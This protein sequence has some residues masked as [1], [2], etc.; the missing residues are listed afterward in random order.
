MTIAVS[1]LVAGIILLLGLA[2]LTFFRDQ[3]KETIRG[4]QSAMVSAL[5]DGIDHDLAVSRDEIAEIAEGITPA[6]LRDPAKAQ[7]LLDMRGK[8]EVRFDNGLVLLSGD[9]RLIA[10]SPVV[11]GRKGGDFSFREYFRKV[12]ATRKPYI[13]GPYISSN[14]NRHPAIMFAAPVIGADGEL[15]GVMGGSMNLMGDNA[16]GRLSR[17]TVGRS[18]YLSLLTGDGVVVMHPDRTRIMGKDAKPLPEPGGSGVRV[19]ARGVPVLSS[20]RQLSAT[21]WV[22]SASYPVSEAFAPIRAAKGYLAA[23]LVGMGVLSVLLVRFLMRKLTAPLLLLTSHIREMPDKEG[24]E[25]FV[26]LASDDETATLAEAF[27]A[28]VRDLD[29]RQEAF[30][31]SEE[32]SRMLFLAVEQNPASIVIT[33]T[34]GTIQYV[35]QRFTENTGYAQSEAIGQNPRILKTQ[36]TDPAVH[37]E[38][39]QTITSGREWRGEFYNRKKNGECFWES[40][41]IAPILNET[42]VITH[43]LAIKEDITER[44][45]MEEALKGERQ[46]L[47][48]LLDGLPGFVYLQAPDYSIR[49]GNQ[50]FRELFGDFE[51]KR[52]HEVIQG[53]NEVCK[54]CPTHGAFETGTPLVW[55]SPGKDG[56][57][58]QINEYPFTDADGSQLVLKLGIDIT[59][60]K[61]VERELRKSQAEL[62]VKHEELN[63]IFRQVEIAKK[64]WESTMDCIGDLVMLVDG[65][66]AIQR[67]NQ[68]VTELT[69]RRFEQ[70]RG[71][72]W[73]GL[74][75]QEGIVSGQEAENRGEY[76]HAPSGR[77]FDL[78]SYPFR[79]AEDANLSA[80]VITLHDTTATKLVAAELERAYAELKETQG[81]LLQQEKMASIGQ[82]AAGVAHEINNPVGF[83]MSN[84][85]TL[86]KYGERLAGFIQAQADALAASP[87]PEKTAELAE[88]RRRLK[89]DQ[90][91]ADLGQLISES[92]DGAERVKKIVQDLK[93][94]SRIDEAEWQTTDINGCLESTLNIVWNELKYRAVVNREFGG[95]PLTRCNPGQLNQ[96]FMNLLV[97][98]A[99]ALERE[100]T[101]TVRSWHGDGAVHVAIADTGCGIPEEIL[102]KIFD[103]F[104]TTKE[105]GK[106]TG[107]GLS[108]S[109][110]IVKKHGGEIRV[111]SEVG[112]GTTFT[113]TLPVIEQ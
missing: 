38:L 33:D 66:G 4:Q 103:P 65:N 16:I 97:N 25:R 98:A 18:G 61:G 13:S 10:E 60:L 27:N 9:G 80:V 15:A 108:I 5:A 78:R 56:R 44:R 21:G 12:A 31:R 91:I 76:Y 109:Y 57:T 90:I 96:V 100:G 67:C 94:F 89:L 20:S 113:V 111:E 82:L 2:G 93:S 26:R 30:G 58:F 106:G 22:L 69:G 53:R 51:G 19:N 59:R 70:L 64:E 34:E 74:F 3:L 71:M 46:R 107:L 55:E 95:L 99:H 42:G 54:E 24:E 32:L 87:S 62:Q 86:G 1:T 110:D 43:F 102:K 84:L 63:H 29:M 36:E 6:T 45:R 28:M 50:R 39:W 40:A 72:A 8:A 83:I 48:S 79:V 73:E 101:I 105:V 14:G 17:L 75:P 77:W 47:F 37:R 41:F 88:L 85:T 68:A 35:N 23:S 49:F 92:I 112:K 81:H 7:R 11:P 52:C 104:F